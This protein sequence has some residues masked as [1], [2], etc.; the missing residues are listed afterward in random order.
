MALFVTKPSIY[1][2][3]QRQEFLMPGY[4]HSGINCSH[5]HGSEFKS[6]AEVSHD[7][8]NINCLIQTQSSCKSLQIHG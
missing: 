3:L 5:V 4:C 6:K 8:L 1:F 2:E 7:I